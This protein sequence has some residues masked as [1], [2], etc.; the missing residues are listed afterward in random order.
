LPFL[1]RPA[2]CNRGSGGTQWGRAPGEHE[3][4]RE[5]TGE[6]AAGGYGSVS[7]YPGYIP[8]EKALEEAD[9]N[10][11]DWCWVAPGSENRMQA[12]LEAARKRR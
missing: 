7:R 4:G 11:R 9:T 2:A 12:A 8:T 10:L 5:L 3:A 1:H 6:N